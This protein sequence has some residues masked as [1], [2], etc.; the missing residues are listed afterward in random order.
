MNSDPVPSPQGSITPLSTRERAPTGRHVA[1]GA[2]LAFLVLASPACT[3]DGGDDPPADASAVKDTS[4][5]PCPAAGDPCDDGDPCTKEDACKADGSCAG[6]AIDCDDGDACTTD[7]CDPKTAKCVAKPVADGKKCDDGSKCTTGDTCTKGACQGKALACDDD[8]PCT[9]DGCKPD[10][11]CVY[12]K[13]AAIECDDGKACTVGD[14]CFG[15]KCDSGKAKTCPDAGPCVNA[16]CDPKTGQCKSSDAKDGSACDD[17][18]GCTTKDVCAK[19]LCVGKAVGCDDDNNCTLDSCD[20]DTGKCVHEGKEM[21]DKP[22]DADDSVCTKGDSCDDGKC[23]AGKEIVCDDDELC[24]KD[25]CDDKKGCVTT[26]L[27]GDTCDDGD[28]C[29]SGDSCDGGS[30]KP[31]KGICKCNSDADCKAFDDGNACNGTLYCDKTGGGSVCSVDE[32]TIVICDKSKDGACAN[33]VCTKTTGKCE[34]KAKNEGGACDA[35]GSVCTQSDSCKSGKCAAGKA[36]DC[37]GGKA[38][39]SSSCDKVKGCVQ[40]NKDG[41]PCDADDDACTAGDKCVAGACVAGKKTVCNDDNPCTT[42]SC[43]AKS[44]ACKYAAG[45]NGATCDADG[46]V[47]TVKDACSG[48]KCVAGKPKICDDSEP[49]TDNNCNKKTGCGFTANNAPCSDSDACTSGDV[50]SGGTCKSGSQTV[51]DDGDACTK[52]SCDKAKGCQYEA[53]AGCNSKDKTWLVMVYMAADNNLEENAIDDINEML[54]VS[55]SDGLNFAIQLDRSAGY[56]SKSVAGISDFDT[57]RRLLIQKGKLSQVKDLG[58]LNT[59]D[60]KHLEEFIAWAASTYK[61]DRNVLV[62]WNHGHAWQGFGGDDSSANADSLSLDEIGTALKNGLAGAKVS[63]LDLVGFDACLM[64]SV[65][66]ALT[67]QPYADYLLASE[68]LEPGHG[69][70]YAVL[71][72][73]TKT[74]NTPVVDVGKAIVDGFAKQAE[75]QKRATSITL[76]LVD[77]SKLQAVD[78]A[79]KAITT[80]L[81]KNLTT[82]V[83]KI[84]QSRDTVQEFGRSSNPDDAYFMIDVGD[85]AKR[86]ADLMPELAGNKDTLLKA[87]DAAVLHQV[88]GTVTGEATGL[89]LYY[90]PLEDW[91]QDDYGKITGVGSWRDLIN[92]FFTEADKIDYQPTFEHAEEGAEGKGSG[93]EFPW[94]LPWPADGP[95]KKPPKPKGIGQAGDGPIGG[96]GTGDEEVELPYI[97]DF[98][99][100]SSTAAMWVFKDFH[101][102]GVSEA[103]WGVDLFPRGLGND[104][105]LNFNDGKTLGCKQNKPLNSRA[106]SPWINIKG[107][108]LLYIA[109]LLPPLAKWADTSLFKL[110]MHFEVKPGVPSGWLPVHYVRPSKLLQPNKQSAIIA[111]TPQ[112]QAAGRIKLSA[113]FKTKGCPQNANLGPALASLKVMSS[114]NP[115]EGKSAGTYCQGD[116]KVSCDDAELLQERERCAFGCKVVN[117]AAACQSQTYGV[118]GEVTVD[119]DKDGVIKVSA[120]MH[121]DTAKNAARAYMRFGFNSS[122]Q[123]RLIGLP[124]E[125]QITKTTYPQFFGRVAGKIAADGTISAEW[126]QYVLVAEHPRGR[127]LLFTRRTLGSKVDHNEVPVDYFLGGSSTCP[128]LLSKDKGYSDVDKDKVPDCLDY[129]V[130]ND[131]AVNFVDNCPWTKNDDQKDSNKDGTGDACSPNHDLGKPKYPC[132]PKLDSQPAIWHIDLDP[133]D[134][135]LISQTLYVRQP[136]G[137]SAVEPDAASMLVPHVTR[138]TGA[139]KPAFFFSKHGRELAPAIAAKHLAKD[140]TFRFLRLSQVPYFKWWTTKQIEQCLDVDGKNYAKGKTGFCYKEDGTPFEVAEKME[141]R[142]LWMQ[143]IVEDIG[144]NG[145]S[146]IYK[147]P[148]PENC[149]AKPHACAKKGQV[150]DCLGNCVDE[151]LK[152]NGTCDHGV[153]LGPHLKCAEHD[154]DGG[155]CTD[156]PDENSVRDCR[157]DCFDRVTLDRVLGNHICNDGNQDLVLPAFTPPE[158]ERVRGPDLRCATFGFDGGDCAFGKPDIPWLCKR[159]DQRVDCQK[160]CMSVVEM[161]ESPPGLTSAQ[162]C[163]PWYECPRFGFDGLKCTPKNA[164]CPQKDPKDPKTICSGHGTCSN[165]ICKCNFGWVGPACQVPRNMGSCCAAKKTPFCDSEFTASCVCL[166]EPKCC[167]KEWSQACVKLAETYCNPT[168]GARKSC[169]EAACGATASAAPKKLAMGR[170]HGCAIGKQ[171]DAWCW[172]EGAWGKLGTGNFKAQLVPTEVEG[173]GKATAIATGEEHSCALVNTQVWCWGSNMSGQL[174]IGSKLVKFKLKPTKV[175]ALFGMGALAAGAAHTCAI[176][177][178]GKV[179]CWGNNDKGQLGRGLPGGIGTAPKA[180][181]GLTAKAITAGMRHTCA[182]DTKGAVWCWGDRTFGALGDGKTS[183][184]P[185]AKPLKIAKSFGLVEIV[186]GDRHTCA[187]NGLGG[188]MCW[189]ENM[190]GQVGVKVSLKTLTVPTPVTVKAAAGA[191]QLA[192][193]GRHSCIRKANGSVWCWGAANQR[194]LGRYGELAG[195]TVKIVM[196][197]PLGAN[198]KG[199]KDLAAG[200][201]TNC[202]L[203]GS[204]NPWCWGANKHGQLGNGRTGERLCQPQCMGRKCGWDG[205]GGVCGR[206]DKSESCTKGQCVACKPNCTG[207]VCGPDGC[208]GVCKPKA[209]IPGKNCTCTFDKPCNRAKGVCTAPSP[210]TGRCGQ[211][212]FD[213]TGRPMCF[214]G[215]Y[216]V[217]YAKSTGIPESKIC[218]SDWKT[219]CLKECTPAC[220]NKKCGPDGCGGTCGLCPLGQKCN[221]AA[222]TCGVGCT[223]ACT[224]KECGDNGCGGTCGACG[225]GATCNAKGTCE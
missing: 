115:C 134:Q 39:S 19:G 193:G 3:G 186:A 45:N 53:I 224:G 2:C 208:G 26:D 74:P 48:G 92:N 63:K 132:D 194:Q 44:G 50:C 183:L 119:C 20:P 176:A 81:G 65:S 179:W 80:A 67:V 109:L 106:T 72:L 173:L 167:T 49:C 147:G 107:H 33:T 143:L 110:D 51:C 70:D 69:W 135:A 90:P 13:Q 55:A 189:G 217:L 30:C 127:S 105:S 117:N 43:D 32:K 161:V 126:D 5:A 102:D 29:T 184:I 59:G 47:C 57:T 145:D 136:Y 138:R 153:K 14:K 114:L 122:M 149:T 185:W 118:A 56:T 120:K 96:M 152:A 177:A 148:V 128:C 142:D 113:L 61:S 190:A 23:V 86:A 159:M 169:P 28:K 216:C 203:D 15:G 41:G 195:A 21:D 171:G 210:C 121:P 89:A 174:G 58:E 85:L 201:D 131:G 220:G 165:G 211:W 6:E 160:Q 204:G 116:W 151:K 178:A 154:W 199:A 209:C 158:F 191:A 124:P 162:A 129:D 223:P 133:S 196:G 75:E 68:D 99:C 206:C 76:S 207:K 60:A 40:S 17:D 82:L 71:D 78:D 64:G 137:I 37:G 4:V 36:V 175:G 38:C 16:A 140:T 213:G 123:S 164:K 221:F 214:C 200:G 181:A 52:D 108:K 218:C 54:K 170:R 139:E 1:L 222:G 101:G 150:R 205:C 111:L 62:L 155:D 180:V 97:E 31:G 10:K 197:G 103:T 144:G 84:A 141:L 35:D 66:T 172:G 42:D 225:P 46:S 112:M 95:T 157:G 9:K 163:R 198:L 11:G 100:T 27:D 156:C 187:R 146:V 168:C 104:C 130:D 77:L 18:N 24:T 215:P 88:T 34:A 73:V 188:V 12:E 94:D 182:L 22:C 91:Y 79:V 192:L 219:Q 87:I 93:V 212:R 25:E 7:S 83:T 166:R 98:G 202:A 8:N 125:D